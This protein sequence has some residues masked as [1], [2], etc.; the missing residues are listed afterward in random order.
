MAEFYVSQE[1]GNHVDPSRVAYENDVVRQL[2]RLYVD[3]ERG[4][5]TVYYEF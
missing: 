1:F 4:S 3:V 5:V 2:F